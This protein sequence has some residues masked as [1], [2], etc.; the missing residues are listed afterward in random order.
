MKAF[1]V[2]VGFQVY[3][4]EG[5]EEI[6]AVREVAKDHVV[7]Y[8]EGSGEF[9]IRGAE[10]ASAHDGKL[11]LDP[12]KITAEMLAATKHAHDLETE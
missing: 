4:S 9:K 10:V 6:G 8:V 1:N 5:G 12:A 3:L 7:V 2:E 11:V